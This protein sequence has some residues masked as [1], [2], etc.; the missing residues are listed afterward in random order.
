MRTIL[1]YRNGYVKK[2]VLLISAF[3]AFLMF[4]Q[5][6]YIKEFIQVGQYA[7]T[8][9][10]YTYA[11]FQQALELNG[12]AKISTSFLENTGVFLGFDD[13]SVVEYTYSYTNFSN[14]F[15]IIA[16]EGNKDHQL[17]FTEKKRDIVVSLKDSSKHY[18]AHQLII[19]EFANLLEVPRRNIETDF[20]PHTLVLTSMRPHLQISMYGMIT[21]LSVGMLTIIL[22]YRH[23]TVGITKSLNFYHL[24]AIDE[25]IDEVISESS[26]MLII[27]DYI[28]YKKTLDFDKQSIYI[29]DI[30]IAG[31]KKFLYRY[32]VV[33]CLDAYAEPIHLYLS[34][35][36]V[37]VILEIL[38]VYQVDYIRDDRFA[39]I[40]LWHLD[41]YR[42]Y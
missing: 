18:D 28:I 38:K 11:E 9:K 24:N 14:H 16:Q 21:L 3:F 5:F 31:I 23:V 2:R 27:K 26:K 19:E 1:A 10:V 13:E 8:P 15:L 30:T 32:E 17:R 20:Y 7:K 37:F 39:S 42:K 40:D 6:P 29:P 12:A 33:L 4:S 41:P 25:N 22:L 35:K 34:K 36:D